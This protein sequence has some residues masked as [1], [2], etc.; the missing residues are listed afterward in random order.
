[1]TL[2]H[3]KI[4]FFNFVALPVSFGIG[5]DYA[6][7]FVLRYDQDPSQGALG[8]LRSTGGAILLCSMTTMLGYTALLG[9]VNQAIR[10]LGLLAVLGEIGC[11]AAAALVLTRIPRLARA[12]RSAPFVD[13]RRPRL[14][15]RAGGV[16]ICRWFSGAT[17]L[18]VVWEGRSVELSEWRRPALLPDES[19]SGIAAGSLG[20]CARFVQLMRAGER[21]D[22]QVGFVFF[23]ARRAVALSVVASLCAPPL[24]VALTARVALAAA[25]AATARG[26]A[27]MRAGAGFGIRAGAIAAPLAIAT[28]AASS[29]PPPRARRGRAGPSVGALALRTRARSASA[30]L[31]PARRARCQDRRSSR[32]EVGSARAA[33]VGVDRWWR[34]SHRPRAR[35]AARHPI[36]VF[37]NARRRAQ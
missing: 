10:S 34:R 20:G 9:S 13:A 25:G 18:L 7:N 11:L 30:A 19:R 14:S 12:S 22:V 1:M 29:C 3:I 28:G 27:T 2:F 4:N 24:G 26:A 8:V 16:K 36:A 5:V 17:A 6:V 31:R 35:C 37:A 21:D 32:L 15:R 33:R 23:T